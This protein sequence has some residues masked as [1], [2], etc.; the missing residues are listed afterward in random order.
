MIHFLPIVTNVPSF[1]NSHH[2]K[3]TPQSLWTWFYNTRLFKEGSTHSILHK[4][5][6]TGPAALD[7]KR[8]EQE[9]EQGVS[10]SSN[11]YLVT[12][13]YSRELS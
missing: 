10:F 2:S 4:S 7:E 1:N 12:V 5:L 9:E 6:G 13:T 3:E 8:A 11:V